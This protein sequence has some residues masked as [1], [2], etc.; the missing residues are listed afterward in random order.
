M[1]QVRVTRSGNNGGRQLL[2][3]LLSSMAAKGETE[4]LLKKCLGNRIGEK[5][6]K[7]RKGGCQTLLLAQRAASE[8]PRSRAAHRSTWVSF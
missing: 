1:R 6:G 2:T 8:G 4:P 5:I 3:P 7:V